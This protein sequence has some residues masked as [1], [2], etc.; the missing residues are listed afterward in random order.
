MKP[1]RRG[2][3]RGV[4]GCALASSFTARARR[5]GN[6]LV[7]IQ[8]TGG[9]DGLNTVVPWSSAVYHN[10]RPSLRIKEDEVL[11]LDDRVG[12][13]PGLPQLKRF[14]DDGK[15]AV[16]QGVGYP[17]PI[18]SHFRSLD[19][20]H[21]GRSAGRLSGEGWIS[22]SCDAAYPENLNSER[23]VHVGVRLPYALRSATRPPVTLSGHDRY[24]LFGRASTKSALHELSQV[25]SA[26]GG[27][28]SEILSR[29]KRVMRDAERSSERIRGALAG[30]EPSVEYPQGTFARSLGMVAAT[31][32]ADLG[33]RVLSV[34]LDGFD[35]HGQQRRTH[36]PLLANLDGSLGAFYRDL[37][38]KGLLDGVVIMVFSEF[39]RRVKEN[40]SAGTDHGTAGPMFLLGGGVRGGL[41]GQEPKL[42][43][44]DQYDIG[45]TTDF[46]SVYSA[47]I[48]RCFNVAPETVLGA[49]YPKLDLFKPR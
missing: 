30:Y 6:V 33:S 19:I 28:R 15:L 7:L 9:N 34:E 32:D 44:L 36:D 26:A 24:R 23:V 8:L 39:G 43:E 4:L 42:T 13:H 22:R 21:T 35:T 12:F 29:I 5:D 16:I 11:K 18:R 37:E 31:I 2:F 41:H 46:R 20:W 45:F 49:T 14:A 25:S 40:A 17:N 10:K 27:R 1:T 38:Q 3:L 48:E 47:V